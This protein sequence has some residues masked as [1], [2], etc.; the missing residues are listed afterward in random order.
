MSQDEL[1]NSNVPGPKVVPQAKR[2]RFSGEYKLHILQEA[3]GCCERGELGAL[4]RREGLYSS[5]LTT[6]RRQREQGQ[7]DRL[8][9][10]LR[11]RKPSVDA[12]LEKELAALT[13]D[14]TDSKHNKLVKDL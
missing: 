4:L 13:K 2:R 10:N 9:P 12:G 11:G 7:M 14:C 6:W 3:D 8:S 1:N 5:H